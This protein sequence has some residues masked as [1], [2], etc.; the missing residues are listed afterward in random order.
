MHQRISTQVWLLRGGFSAI[1]H[2]RKLIEA[3]RAREMPVHQQEMEATMT[4]TSE[5]TKPAS[6]IVA[7]DTTS[8]PP[9]SPSLYVD[10]ASMRV[11]LPTIAGDHIVSVSI[12][13]WLLK[14]PEIFEPK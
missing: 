13:G 12:R 8:I 3:V 11:P 5:V 14:K 9:L 2:R 10:T 6:T 7:A 1:A 4:R